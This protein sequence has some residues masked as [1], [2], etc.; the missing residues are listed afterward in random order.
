MGI[1]NLSI[2]EALQS[3]LEEEQAICEELQEKVKLSNIVISSIQTTITAITN[4]MLVSHDS[5]A[6]KTSIANSLFKYN[7]SSSWKEKIISY[8]KFMGIAVSNS[9]IINEFYNQEPQKKDKKKLTNLVSGAMSFLVRSGKV[10]AYK[11][12]KMKG[13]YYANPLWFND[14]GELNEENKPFINEENSW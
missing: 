13:A 2:I 7:K 4:P 6:I 14:Q 5:N 9:E 12:K 8:I 3:R 1:N 11:P 10:R